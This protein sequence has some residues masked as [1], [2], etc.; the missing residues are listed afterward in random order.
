MQDFLKFMCYMNCLGHYTNDSKGFEVAIFTTVICGWPF[1][2]LAETPT[3]NAYYNM[4]DQ[5]KD[6]SP[7]DGSRAAL[8][9]VR[10]KQDMDTAEQY[11]KFREL[12]FSRVYWLLLSFFAFAGGVVLA[13][14]FGWL[15]LDYRIVVTMLGTVAVSVISVFMSM[16]RAVF[17]LLAR[18]TK[19]DR[20]TTTTEGP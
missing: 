17:G 20:H 4:P 13:Q 1:S 2:Y 10:E 5:K 12:L 19:K 6:L 16:T 14:G 11:A 18:R 15:D 3:N 8:D 7:P 9:F